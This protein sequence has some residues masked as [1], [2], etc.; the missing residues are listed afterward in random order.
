MAWVATGRAAAADVVPDGAFVAVG[1][2]DA[3]ARLARVLRDRRPEVVVTYEPAG[4]YGHPDHVHAHRVVGA[5]GRARRAAGPGRGAA[6]RGRGRAV[7]G[8]ARRRPARRGA[9][10][11]PDLRA[12]RDARA[13][14]PALTLPDPAGP[15]PSVAVDPAAVDLR[16]DTAA[17]LDR[18]ADALRAHGTQVGSVALAPP[19]PLAL[20]EA[21]TPLGHRGRRLAGCYALSNDVLAPLLDAEWYRFAPGSPRRTV[22]WPAAVRPVA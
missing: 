11:S 12:A 15:L 6:A 1:V 9:P 21:T 7:G 22:S 18:V 19:V 13:E 17:V 14:R 8:R 10:G 5:R 4:G 3:A 20:G 2:D 16:V